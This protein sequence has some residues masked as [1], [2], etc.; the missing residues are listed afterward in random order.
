MSL[1]SG[2]SSANAPLVLGSVTPRLWTP[3]LITG[4]P[5]PC[6]CGCALTPDTSE[7]FDWVTF[8]RDSMNREPYPW[9]RWT[10]IHGGELLP[11][12]RPRFRYVWVIVARQNGKTEVPVMLSGY[13]M[14]I[15]GVPLILGTSTKLDY[16]KESWK[17]LITLIDK[18]KDPGVAK[19]L[20]PRRW[21]REANG[22]QECWC[23]RDDDHVDLSRYKIAASNEEGGRS[24]TVHR[25][26]CDEIRQ[27]HDYSAM[28]AIE[29]AMQAVPD[30]QLWALSN[31]GDDRSIVL[32]E[33][34]A[35]AMQF[36]ATG[37]GDW[38]TGWFEYSS[39][40]DARADD[41]YALAQAN[42]QFNRTI[43]GDDLVRAGAKA[44]R[45]GGEK[46][47]K[48]RT[49]AMCITVDKLT[50][51]ISPEPWQ[52][53]CVPGSLAALRDRVALVFDVALDGRHATL[54]AA[55][56]LP[57]GE[58]TRVEPVAAWSEDD[59]QRPMSG[60]IAQLKALITKIRPKAFGWL[61]G[62]PAAM[63]AAEFKPAPV[64]PGG[65]NHPPKWLPRGTKIQEIRAELPDVCMGFEEQVRTLKI[66]H[67]G[68]PL[69]NAHVLGAERLSWGDRWVFARRG[70]HCDAA[71]S[72]AGAVHLARTLPPPVGKPR[73][74][75]VVDDDE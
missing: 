52:V 35:E 54:S 9:Q 70:G 43:D 7:G 17:K 26:I 21:Y 65:I 58:L 24:L 67:S 31:A 69:Q 22:E 32:N 30:A 40:P 73:L 1:G 39:P 53:C 57:G 4:P 11:D 19:M 50:P 3:P 47:A 72:A 64:T 51:A 23:Y 8:A 38:R 13:W 27:H 10:A 28:S 25:G 74:T 36:I 5:G 2:V 46:L 55:A 18:S 66:L 15:A 48:F 20:P 37:Q 14:F 75:V 60:L 59:P 34:R 56:T 68:D 49:E 44:M 41:Q 33:A 45:A 16:A 61:P 71:Y 42:P 62:G 12:G 29:F 6:G 63:Y